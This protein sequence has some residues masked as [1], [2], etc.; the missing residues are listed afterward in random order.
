V[1]FISAKFAHPKYHSYENEQGD[2]AARGFEGERH[3]RVSAVLIGS[4]AQV[5]NLSVVNLASFG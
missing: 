3:E 1:T 5:T 4:L 2:S